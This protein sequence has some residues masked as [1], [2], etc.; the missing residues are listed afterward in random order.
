MAS[1]LWKV[2]C[3]VLALAIAVFATIRLVFLQVVL[4]LLQALPREFIPK[5][6]PERFLKKGFSPGV[7]YKTFLQLVWVRY[8]HLLCPLNVGLEAPN[9]NI[10]TLEKVGKK[11][12]DFEKV[13][14]PLVVN[15]GSCS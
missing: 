12:L 2:R 6:V 15:F 7:S 9:I 14:R 4:K 1:I 13:G 3:A 8:L 5:R 10:L 11:L